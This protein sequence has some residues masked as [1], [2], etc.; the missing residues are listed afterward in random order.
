M[1]AKGLAETND[2]GVQRYWSLNFF[3][4]LGATTPFYSRLFVSIRGLPPYLRPPAVV[5]VVF[6]PAFAHLTNLGP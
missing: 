1:D 3:C 6:C 2:R 5:F 4:V